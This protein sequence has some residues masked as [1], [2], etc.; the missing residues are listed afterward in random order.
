[1]LKMTDFLIPNQKLL[2]T[3]VDKGLGSLVVEKSKAAGCKGGTILP[4]TGTRK[5]AGGFSLFGMA[6]EPEKDVIFSVID[7]DISE[8][9]LQRITEGT[10]I[11]KPGRGI[12]FILNI[13]NIAGLSHVLS[14]I[15]KNPADPHQDILDGNASESVTIKKVQPSP[16]KSSDMKASENF[17]LIVSIV[18]KGSC[19]KVVEAS[20]KAGAEGGTI[21]YGRGTGIREK[22][23]LFSM[24]IEPEKEV[25]LTLI[26]R[27]KTKQVL[28]EIVEAT[29][30]NQPGRGIAFVLD[31]ES[32]AGICHQIS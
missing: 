10:K 3:I 23:K 2:I 24:L 8:A 25:I 16:K 14:Q 31:V 27:E 26:P 19:D 30:L 6:A 20:R 13:E 29:E 22:T 4:G 32:T 1:M 9:V 12:A 17:Q 7:A 5:E 11:D 18:D 21:I 28:Q 15:A